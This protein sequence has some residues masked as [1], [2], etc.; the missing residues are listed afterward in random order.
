MSYPLARL[1][2]RLEAK[3]FE[4]ESLELQGAPA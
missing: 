1:A 3:L 2:A 4:T